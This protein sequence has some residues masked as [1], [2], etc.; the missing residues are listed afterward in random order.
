MS[1]RNCSP[2]TPATAPRCRPASN[3][4]AAPQAGPGQDPSADTDKF[5]AAI[6][7]RLDN[8]AIAVDAAET[9]PS[10]QRRAAHASIDSELGAI[11]ADVLARL[12]VRADPSRGKLR[13]AYRMSRYPIS[14]TQFQSRERGLPAGEVFE[15][16]DGC[17]GDGSVDVL[18]T[19]GRGRCRGSAVRRS[20][21]VRCA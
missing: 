8:L 2:S 16:A 14:G 20:S 10:A 19:K 17:G 15:G 11:D 9:M 6:G 4:P 12:G 18:G 13:P 5:V 1:P 21:G 3:R 7:T